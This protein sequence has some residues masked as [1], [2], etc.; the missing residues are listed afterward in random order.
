MR[1]EKEQRRE[2]RFSTM[3]I[4]ESVECKKTKPI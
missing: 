2:K 3:W 1:R 4:V